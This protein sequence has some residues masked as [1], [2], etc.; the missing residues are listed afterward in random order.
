MISFE[1]FQSL[2]KVGCSRMTPP[3]QAPPPC[4]ADGQVSGL[5][6]GGVMPPCVAANAG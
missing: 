1:D 4:G 2:P 3:P 6:T 5:M